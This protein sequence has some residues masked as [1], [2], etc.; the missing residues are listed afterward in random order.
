MPKVVSLKRSL[1]TDDLT[2]SGQSKKHITDEVYD[3]I[4]RTGAKCVPTSAIQDKKE[5]GSQYHETG[6]LRTKPGK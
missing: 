6:A 2:E 1:S 5:Q 4:H 3:D